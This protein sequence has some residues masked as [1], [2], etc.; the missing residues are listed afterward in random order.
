VVVPSLDIPQPVVVP[1][2]DIPQPDVELNL[3][4]HWEV[5]PNRGNLLGPLAGVEPNRG[6]LLGP[7]AGVVPSLDIPQPDVELN[8]DSRLKPVEQSLDN[9]LLVLD[10]RRLDNLTFFGCFFISSRRVTD[11]VIS[12]RESEVMS[13][14]LDYTKIWLCDVFVAS[15]LQSK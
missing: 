15:Q 5:E 14:S 10:N 8:L 9:P 12:R 3:D 7:L 11:S 13:D 4:S 1:S 2:L 6:N